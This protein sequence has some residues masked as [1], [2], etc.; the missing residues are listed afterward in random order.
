MAVL[1]A[2]GRRGKTGLR[3]QEPTRRCSV[4]G[5]PKPRSEL[6]SDHKNLR[7]VDPPICRTCRKD[8]REAGRAERDAA[9]DAQWPPPDV[10]G[11]PRNEASEPDGAAEVS[12]GRQAVYRVQELRREAPS[13]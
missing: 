13:A 12:G 11:V 9:I 6:A 1:T 3:D 4:C 10:L 7:P 2:D 5:N 8:Q